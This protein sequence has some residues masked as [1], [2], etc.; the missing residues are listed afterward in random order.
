MFPVRSFS[1]YA[2]LFVQ[3]PVFWERFGLWRF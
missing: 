3:T 1:G 2:V